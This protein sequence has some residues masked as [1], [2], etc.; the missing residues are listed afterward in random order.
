M[1]KVVYIEID[2]EITSIVDRV[3]HLKQNPLHLVVPRKAILFQSLVNLK[4]LH[5]KLKELDKTLVLVTTDPNGKHLA[6]KLGIEVQRRVEVEK[7]EA[8]PEET[9]ELRIQPIQA[10]QNEVIREQPK[11]FT[12]KKISIAELIR[13]F[14]LKRQ[15]GED[16]SILTPLQGRSRRFWSLLLV[17]S[18]GLFLLIGYIALPGATILIRPSFDSI[19]HTLNITLADKR[20]NQNLL[21]QNKPHVIPSEEVIVITKQTKVFNTTS[22]EFYGQPAQGK[23][24]LINTTGE[25]WDFKTGTR[26]QT[27]KGIIFRTEKSVTI[28]AATSS[29][30]GALT[31]AKIEV[32][33][34]ADPFDSLGEPV[35]DRGNVPQSRFFLPGLSKL[36]QRRIWGESLSPMMGGITRY[37]KVVKSEDIESAKQQIKD[38]L[39]L[40]AKEELRQEL[41]NQNQLNHTHLTIL[42]DRRYLKTEL[43][44]LRISE[45]LEGSSRDK[46]EVFAKIRA[47]GIAYDFDQLFGLLK[48]ELKT[49]VHPERV[50]R[51]D[52]IDPKSLSYE[53]IDQD[54]ISGLIKLTVTLKG[55]EEFIVDEEGGVGQKFAQRIKDKIVSL[56]V[57]EA[58]NLL[59]NL[60]EVEAVKIDTWP[61]WI[62][63]IPHLPENIK[64]KRMKNE[65]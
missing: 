57:E 64:I 37:Q 40:L 39:I 59:Q 3:R 43:L 61:F 51:E 47:Q 8:A 23:L 12:E 15:K 29:P 30:T 19:D 56:P 36:N 9:M 16:R 18:L 49:R 50:L 46:F 14:R 4:I 17:L 27:E 5:E 6:E 38:N 10:R 52:L 48:Q 25:S 11:R 7:M 34:K 44:D 55:I 22:Q 65:F 13:E 1:K 60:P 53:V 24:T 26:F 31:P 45:G 54:P 58:K 42:D 21:L 2:E 32:L 62:S 33:V 63:T 20:R 28:P 35:G 41:F